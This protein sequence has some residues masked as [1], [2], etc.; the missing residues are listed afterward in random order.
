MKCNLLKMDMIQF[1]NKSK[2]TR[3]DPEFS[4]RKNLHGILRSNY[5]FC[6]NFQPGS[7]ANNRTYE[8]TVTQDNRTG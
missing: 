3:L 6:D 4:A 7:S 8:A 2:I 5:Y 1:C